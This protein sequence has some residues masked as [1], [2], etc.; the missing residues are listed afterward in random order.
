MATAGPAYIDDISCPSGT[1]DL[2]NCSMQFYLGGTNCAQG[3]V[4]VNCAPAPPQWL[5]AVKNIGVD[6]QVRGPVRVQ[7]SEGDYP[8]GSVCGRDATMTSDTLLAVCL[9]AGVTPPPWGASQL[10]PAVGG[11]S[12]PVYVDH[13]V[14]AAPPLASLNDCQFEF[15]INGSTTCGVNES[16]DVDCAPPPPSW[17]V[18]IDV[19]GDPLV[20]LVRGPVVITPVAR[21]GAA[22]ASGS[23]CGAGD[24]VRAVAVA[25][26]LC[27]QSGITPPPWNAS[28]FRFAWT[29]AA[30]SRPGYIPSVNI[31][32]CSLGAASRLEECQ[33]R[34]VVNGSCTAETGVV[35]I[36]CAP[37]APIGWWRVTVAPSPTAPGQAS[38]AFVGAISVAFSH[39]TTEMVPRGCCVDSVATAAR[40]DL[41]AEAMC[42]ASG[43]RIPEWGAARLNGTGEAP[44]P[45]AAPAYLHRLVCNA[46]STQPLGPNATA[47][48]DFDFLVNGSV[49]SDAGYLLSVDCFPR[50]WDPDSW[51]VRVAGA[52]DGDEDVVRVAPNL[53]SGDNST[54]S[55]GVVCGDASFNNV[56]ATVACRTANKSVAPWGAVAGVGAAVASSPHPWMA[57][58]RCS[59]YRSTALAESCN[60]TFVRPDQAAALCPS[61]LAAT[62]WCDPPSSGAPAAGGSDASAFRT[63]RALSTCQGCTAAT[64]SSGCSWCSGPATRFCTSGSCAE[65]RPSA[66]CSE[67]SP[68]WANGPTSNQSING[69]FLAGRAATDLVTDGVISLPPGAGLVVVD[70]ELVVVV[71]SNN[72]VGAGANASKGALA[73]AGSSAIV[74]V[75]EK[76]ATVLNVSYGDA[77]MTVTTA[78]VPLGA[79]S[80]GVRGAGYLPTCGV[81]LLDACSGLINVSGAVV[82]PRPVGSM[83]SGTGGATFVSLTTMEGSSAFAITTGPCAGVTLVNAATWTATSL[84]AAPAASCNAT[85]RGSGVIVFD[86]ATGAASPGG[87]A[88]AVALCGGAFIATTDVIW[89]VNHVRFANA[90]DSFAWPALEIMA[91]PPFGLRIVSPFDA[92]SSTTSPSANVTWR[93]VDECTGAFI[94]SQ[95]P[96]AVPFPAKPLARCGNLLLFL[97][98]YVVDIV[99]SVL[100]PVTGLP[101]PWKLTSAVC[102]N[103]TATGAYAFKA[104]VQ[105]ADA[106]AEPNATTPSTIAIAGVAFIS[107]SGEVDHL[108]IRM[109]A[110]AT[111]CF[112]SDNRGDPITLPCSRAA[113]GW[114]ATAAR[115]EFIRHVVAKSEHSSGASQFTALALSSGACVVTT[116]LTDPAGQAVTNISAVATAPCSD[117]SPQLLSHQAVDGWILRGAIAGDADAMV[118]SELPLTAVVPVGDAAVNGFV[119]AMGCAPRGQ[120]PPQQYCSNLSVMGVDFRNSFVTLHRRGLPQQRL[121][122]VPVV[123]SAMYAVRNGTTCSTLLEF[124]AWLPEGGPERTLLVDTILDVFGVALDPVGAR[125]CSTAIPGSTATDDVFVLVNRTGGSLT[126]TAAACVVYCNMTSTYPMAP[127]QWA[128]SLIDSGSHAFPVDRLRSV[129]WEPCDDKTAWSRSFLVLPFQAAATHSTDDS[130]QRYHFSMTHHMLTRPPAE[131]DTE[132]LDDV[133]APQ[134]VLTKNTSTDD[135]NTALMMSAASCFLSYGVSPAASDY[136]YD[137][138]KSPIDCG[139]ECQRMKFAWQFCREQPPAAGFLVSFVCQPNGDVSIVLSANFSDDP[140]TLSQL[141]QTPA[142]LTSA[143]GDTSSGHCDTSNTQRLRL[144]CTPCFYFLQAGVIATPYSL[145]LLIVGKN[146]VLLVII[147]FVLA[148]PVVRRFQARLLETIVEAFV[149][150]AANFALMSD[151]RHHIHGSIN[152]RQMEQH[153]FDDELVHLFKARG[154]HHG[155]SDEFKLYYFRS[156]CLSG[157]RHINVANEQTVKRL[158]ILHTSFQQREESR[159]QFVLLGSEDWD[160]D[161]AL[162]N[163]RPADD[164]AAHHHTS[165]GR[166]INHTM[167]ASSESVPLLVKTAE[168]V[169]PQRASDS[170]ET[171]AESAS[172]KPPLPLGESSS[173]PASP[174]ISGTLPAVNRLGAGRTVPIGSVESCVSAPSDESHAPEPPGE[175][176]TGRLASKVSPPLPNPQQ[177]HGYFR[178]A[179]GPPERQSILSLPTASDAGGS[180]LEEATATLEGTLRDFVRLAQFEVVEMPSLSTRVLSPPK[181]TLLLQLGFCLFSYIIYLVAACDRISLMNPWQ[182]YSVIYFRYF[183]SVSTFGLFVDSLLFVFYNNDVMGRTVWQKTVDFASLL[184]PLRCLRRQR[185]RLLL[186]DSRAASADSGAAAAVKGRGVFYLALTLSLPG[187]CTHLIP[188][189]LIFLPF[190]LCGVVLIMAVLTVFRKV[191]ERFKLRTGPR[192]VLRYAL[193]RSSLIFSVTITAQTIMNLTT[194]FY[195]GITPAGD[196][197]QQANGATAT[198]PYLL[199]ASDSTGSTFGRHWVVTVTTAMTAQSW[200]CAWFIYVEGWLHNQVQLFWNL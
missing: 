82:F 27:L 123:T 55:F 15:Y 136:I 17:R 148:L 127:P 183:N 171:S 8:Q 192:A 188:G 74:A 98:G 77:G 162:P 49:C 133:C 64:A 72:T 199:I 21:N 38:S 138:F 182:Q 37:P 13:L 159:R 42:R 26:M 111:S 20:G 117:S 168:T 155:P 160:H 147:S 91:V 180:E 95:P 2:A 22:L 99:T 102:Q 190:T 189:A 36:D 60:F 104:L 57:Q 92:D 179:M 6:G 125:F 47:S 73:I 115:V 14:C 39:G 174:V 66:S 135:G 141:R 139:E 56:A 58:L 122:H 84:R 146:V 83:L 178:G 200:T 71:A 170:R 128:A 53:P 161:D 132:R 70:Q 119:F 169:C 88:Q 124:G 175:G 116:C 198:H 137:L 93:L 45:Q 29:G 4:A 96:W 185:H 25:N 152:P 184:V 3:A 76:Q 44:F 24:P 50:P 78:V 81:V 193:F 80:C 172:A 142:L 186:R 69:T 181:F 68:P 196:S 97:P 173:C 166:V 75:S 131:L 94:V 89:G 10:P 11:N 140:P 113:V 63:C 191:E 12:P 9:L 121:S 165:S 40:A 103:D 144:R 35:G 126:L 118:P 43:I 107:P 61:A 153:D 156:V 48:C 28:V 1:D 194:I 157:H 32:N 134:C 46:S 52:G 130:L 41:T 105:V 109:T 197:A 67:A 154:L 65:G 19:S 108:S 54:S 33:F 100:I 51:V 101:A 167:A 62:A 163:Y 195:W 151:L 110:N 149:P 18:S 86:A 164:T 112:A 34:F 79:H 176:G 150:R 145:I 7:P 158:F 5:V 85:A 177:Q 90:T 16:L 187:L 31:I 87:G 129:Q 114:V 23:I 59:N 120:K 106:R 30:T 143:W